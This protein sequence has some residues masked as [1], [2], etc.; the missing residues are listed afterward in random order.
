MLPQG[1]LGVLQQ[2]SLGIFKKDFPRFRNRVWGVS[3]PAAEAKG[4]VIST[5]GTGI[6]CLLS[7]RSLKFIAG[8][9]SKT[10]FKCR[11]MSASL[12]SV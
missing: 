2:T 1:P 3:L 10:G 7:V 12:T 5:V 11:Q 9:A 4:A 8:W 6:K